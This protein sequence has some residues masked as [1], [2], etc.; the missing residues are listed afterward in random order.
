MDFQGQHEDLAEE[1]S[2][3]RATATKASERHVRVEAEL[4]ELRNA[5]D[6]DNG[7]LQVSV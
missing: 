4:L 7:L 3:A 1:C 2:K 5:A 6:T